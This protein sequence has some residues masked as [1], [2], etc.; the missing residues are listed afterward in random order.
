MWIDALCI[1]QTNSSERTHQLRTMRTIFEQATSTTI[2][3][4][5]ATGQNF[6]LAV[7]WL[8][9]LSSDETLHLVPD[10]TP[11]AE[12]GG[13]HISSPDIITGCRALFDNA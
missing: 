3:L 8:E 1:D 7:K 9:R 10:S 5:P 6:S 12:I 11:Y 13:K 2:W 4:G